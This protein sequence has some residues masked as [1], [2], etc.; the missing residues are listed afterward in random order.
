MFK[1]QALIPLIAIPRGAISIK[2][3]MGFSTCKLLTDVDVMCGVQGRC[4]Y[5]LTMLETLAL[6]N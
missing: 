6:G 2:P 5:I 4:F 1:W 3:I